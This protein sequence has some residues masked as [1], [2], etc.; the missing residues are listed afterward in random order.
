MKKLLTIL[1]FAVPLCAQPLKLP[2]SFDKLAAKAAESVEVTLDSSMLQLA[3]RFLSDKKAD[4]AQTRKLIEGLKGIWVRSFEFTQP[5]EYSMA[6]VEAFRAQLKAPL[7]SRVVGV[8]SKKEQETADV[9]F[10]TENGKVTGL[11]VIAAEP[12]ELTIVSIDGLIDPEQ[13]SKLGGQFG[14]PKVEVPKGEK[15]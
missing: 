4:E 8:Q 5:G 12:K 13:L 11:A 15:K 3:G 10:R 1:M 14:I 2:Q 7:W 6:D 9:F